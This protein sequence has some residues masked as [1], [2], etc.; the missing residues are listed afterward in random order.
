MATGTPSASR[1]SGPGHPHASKGTARHDGAVPFFF[2]RVAVLIAAGVVGYTDSRMGSSDQPLRIRLRGATRRSTAR[3]AVL[4]LNGA[5]RD[6]L[7]RAV[8]LAGQ[9]CGARI[10]VAV[11][12]GLES[13]RAAGSTPDLFVGDADS[14]RARPGDLAS[15][16]YPRD[17]DLS[18]FS[19]ALA[20]VR[21][22]NAEVVTVA[23]LIGGRLDHEWANL[24]EAGAHARRFAGIVAP[25]ERG[26]VVVTAHGCS[27]ET[28]PGRLVSLF[29]L[30]GS[31]TVTLRGTRWKLRDRRIRPGSRGLSNVTGKKLDLVVHAGVVAVV[32]PD[33]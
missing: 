3:G 2:V 32:F 16:L 26:V 20:E 13:C 11:D 8:D 23:G 1:C 15:A 30:G 31:A 9:L 10:L 29:V 24:F 17:K 7:R 25:T 4:V 14:S 19:A 6:D 18:D 5:S 21:R 28:V 12:G 27:V 22:R 33:E